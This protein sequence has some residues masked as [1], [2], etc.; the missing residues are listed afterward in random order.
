MFSSHKT[1]EQG[2]WLIFA[3]LPQHL[4]RS[5]SGRER[6]NIEK[7]K[8]SVILSVIKMYCSCIQ[9]D[10]QSGEESKSFFTLFSSQH[11]QINMKLSLLWLLGKPH[12][13]VTAFL[14]CKSASK[15]SGM[16]PSSV[17]TVHWPLTCWVNWT[18]LNVLFKMYDPNPIKVG[19]KW[20]VHVG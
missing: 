5:G 9:P 4:P 20:H 14:Y 6:G 16:Y 10:F 1:E 7:K 18:P 11:A 8:K 17:H 12:L 19:W 15:S 3:I 2:C 13:T